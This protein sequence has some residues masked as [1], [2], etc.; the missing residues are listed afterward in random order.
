MMCVTGRRR[1][2]RGQG[3]DQGVRRQAAHEQPRLLYTARRHRRRYAVLY[4]IL[5]HTV[6]HAIKYVTMLTL[7]YIILDFCMLVLHFI[8][9]LT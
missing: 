6:L 2:H 5:L 7:V 3:R 8:R 4:T 1:D 9:C